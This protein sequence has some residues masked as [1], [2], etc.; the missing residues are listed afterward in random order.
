MSLVRNPPT[1][2]TNETK[3]NHS[4]ERE[5]RSVRTA[6]ATP[7]VSDAENN[8]KRALVASTSA[9]QRRCSESR[10]GPIGKR[11]PPALRGDGNQTPT[12]PRTRW[13]SQ[14]QHPPSLAGENLDGPAR[15][16]WSER[17]DKHDGAL[18]VSPR[19]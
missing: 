5:H 4:D 12:V 2:A 13:A 14:R 10:G 6:Q 11:A 15:G 3:P 16:T 18:R 19:G 17:E 8:R 9:A 1:R 7:S